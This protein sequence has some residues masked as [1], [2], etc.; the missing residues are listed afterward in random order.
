M[1]MEKTW[2]VI[3]AQA[4]A[5]TR[6]SWTDFSMSRTAEQDSETKDFRFTGEG[7]TWRRRLGVVSVGGAVAATAIL[8]SV[9]L[10]SHQEASAAATVSAAAVPAGLG[11]DNPPAPTGAPAMPQDMPGMDMGGGSAPTPAPPADMPQ[12]MP[13]MDMGGSTPEPTINSDMPPEMPG[14]DMPGDSHEH[15]GG[16]EVAA[17]RPLAPVLGTFGGASSAVLLSAGMLRR[18]DRAASLAKKAAR[19]AG[20]A[21]K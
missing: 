7:A 18:K 14:M 9:I 3:T 16:T 21:K 8:G 11:F 19:I 2:A 20:R 12:D 17:K 15:G 6:E 4:R 1:V 5:M 13:G 10:T